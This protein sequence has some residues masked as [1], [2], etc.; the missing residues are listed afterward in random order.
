LPLPLPLLLL[1][2]GAL[3]TDVAAAAL[4]KGGI[5]DGDDEVS[6]FMFIRVDENA[7][8]SVSD[9]DDV[10]ICTVVTRLYTSSASMNCI[11]RWTRTVP[12]FGASGLRYCVANVE[13]PIFV[14]C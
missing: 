6:T 14:V 3:M 2:S 8:A 12:T 5:V 7:S 13:Y 10:V 9:A 4:E 1:L 11:S